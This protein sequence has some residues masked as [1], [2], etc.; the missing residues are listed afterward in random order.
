MTDLKTDEEKAEELKQWW[1]DNGTSVLAGVALAIAGTFGWQQWQA[2]QKAQTE[3]AS[4]L[5]A[6]IKSGSGD[7]A[8]TTEKLISEYSSTPYAAFAALEKAKDAEE[9]GDNK[10][11]I[12]A[13]KIAADSKQVNVARIAKLRLIRS[14]IANG[15]LDEANT[16][17]SEKLPSA[18][19]SLHE[20]LKGDLYFAK[21]EID[22]ARQSYD[23][24]ILSAGKDSVEYLKMKRNNLG[25]GA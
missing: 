20:E 6:Q 11:S 18:Y 1:R 24:A 3:T 10:A 9:K 25:E 4:Q 14:L 23:R 7:K 22:K 21:K 16:L 19:T 15:K 2:H 8:K 12:E 5:L 13:L 17:L